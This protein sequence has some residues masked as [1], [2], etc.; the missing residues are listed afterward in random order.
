MDKV[1]K[2]FVVGATDPRGPSA[3]N[4]EMCD[5][6]VEA[7][8]RAKKHLGQPDAQVTFWC[9][10]PVGYARVRLPGETEEDLRAEAEA[11]RQQEQKAKED[12]PG[13]KA[14]L[15]EQAAAGQ[16]AGGTGST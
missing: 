10:P 14:A 9:S 2:V 1:G 6:V 13:R 11:Q 8:E 15:E 3:L 5:S 4:W 7:V 12:C 16:A